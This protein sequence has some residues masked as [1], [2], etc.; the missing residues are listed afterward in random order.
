MH[1]LLFIS[2]CVLIRR[3]YLNFVVNAGCGIPLLAT[4]N[5]DNLLIDLIN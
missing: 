3:S 5:G 4:K 1:S 2:V